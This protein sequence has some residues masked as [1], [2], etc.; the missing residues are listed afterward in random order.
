[1][2]LTGAA[3]AQPSKT[4]DATFLR[5][6]QGDYSHLIVKD[7]NGQEKDF[8]LWSKGKWDAVLSNP[9]SWK[10]KRVRL[11]WRKVT[12]NIPEAGG[13]L[14]LDEATSIRVLK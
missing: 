2:L 1:M 13:N 5:I 12:R 10:G 9:E 3:A 6:D 14:E 4:L 8:W 7:K 11:T